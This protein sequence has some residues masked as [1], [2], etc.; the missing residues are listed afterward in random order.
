MIALSF[1]SLALAGIPWILIG[2]SQ[3][4][5]PNIGGFFG[6]LDY[7]GFSGVGADA[8]VAA[9]PPLA[10]MIFQMFLQR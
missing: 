6:N 10:F 4:F 2:C 1:I 5:G 9:Y 8:G 3:A 7:F